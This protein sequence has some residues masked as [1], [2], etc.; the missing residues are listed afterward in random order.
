MIRSFGGPDRPARIAAAEATLIRALSLAPDHAL[1]HLYLG[2]VQAA[3][4]RAAQGLAELERALQLDRNLALA[5]ALIGYAK[6]YVGRAEDCEGHVQE[7]LRL[8]PRDVYAFAWLAI[9]AAAKLH[10]GD[11]EEAAQWSRRSIEANRNVPVSHLWLAAA[12]AGL[13]RL[14]EARA[15]A[16]TGLALNPAFTLATHFRAGAPSGPPLLLAQRERI[17]DLLRR[18]G[19][20]EG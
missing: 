17:Y 11:D 4:N 3:S 20:P 9:A 6:I 15:A 14:D 19:V 1:A 7:A 18:A 12:L 10:V 16:V 5:H 2:T 13:G 8:S